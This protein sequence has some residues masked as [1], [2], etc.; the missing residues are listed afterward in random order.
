MIVAAHMTSSGISEWSGTAQGLEQ[1]GF[2]NMLGYSIEFV[3]FLAI[4]PSL[5]II[6][7]MTSDKRVLKN[8]N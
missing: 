2:G 6:G 5:I 1:I 3:Y 7:L 4:I 8:E